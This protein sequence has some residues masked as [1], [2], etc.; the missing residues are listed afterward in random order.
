MAPSTGESDENK[1]L[2]RDE[3]EN[4][5]CGEQDRGLIRWSWDGSAALRVGQW[6]FETELMVGPLQSCMVSP[7]TFKI[8]KG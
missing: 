3:V 7:S 4:S 5:H 8:Q 6:R 2:R 1:C